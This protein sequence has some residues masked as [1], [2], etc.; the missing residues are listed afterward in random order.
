MPKTWSRG[1][2][3]VIFPTP[4][5]CGAHT[6]GVG[7]SV[8]RGCKCTRGPILLAPCH[9]LRRR[10]R[11]MAGVGAEGLGFIGRGVGFM[12]VAVLMLCEGHGDILSRLQLLKDSIYI[13]ALGF[14][15]RG[16][17]SA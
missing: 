8:L 14:G 9:L 17:P 5:Q 4:Q 3:C 2:Q 7:I 6:P 13:V 15:T 11:P 12:A 16:H 1:W 10:S